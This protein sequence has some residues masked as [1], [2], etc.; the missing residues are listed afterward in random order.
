VKLATKWRHVALKW[1]A[2]RISRYQ[3]ETRG[4]NWAA[5]SGQKKKPNFERKQVHAKA[6]NPKRKEKE[7][8]NKK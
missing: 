2:T 5:A 4:R 7:K 8:S 1:L 6:I 3:T